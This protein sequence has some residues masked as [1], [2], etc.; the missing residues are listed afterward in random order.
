MPNRFVE[1]R[2]LAAVVAR[3]P[4]SKASQR[5]ELTAG[6]S[7]Y[8]RPQVEK[9]AS[10]RKGQQPQFTTRS[11]NAAS[12]SSKIAAARQQPR[13][14]PS[15]RLIEL[16]KQ[17]VGPSFKGASGQR[18]DTPQGAD[19]SRGSVQ[20]G[21]LAAVQRRIPNQPASKPALTG[22]RAQWAAE[23]KAGLD[24]ARAQRGSQSKNGRGPV[25]N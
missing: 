13:S 2:F 11:G 22:E 21:N 1:G 16:R 15:P 12:L 8:Q 20:L 24:I 9:S 23:F 6:R 3:Q 14:D 4:R 18:K 17:W 5:V 19:R 7:A 25:K 10:G